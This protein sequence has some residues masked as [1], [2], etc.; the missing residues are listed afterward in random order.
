MTI[1]NMLMSVE[2]LIRADDKGMDYLEIQKQ[3]RQELQPASWGCLL[4]ERLAT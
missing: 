4:L 3:A 1:I 2:N